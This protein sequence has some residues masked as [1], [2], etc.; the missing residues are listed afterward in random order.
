[1]KLPHRRHFLH[2]AGGA[3]VLP[4]VAR[5]AKAETYPARPVRLIVG[6][7]P[8]GSTDIAARVIAQWL[9]EQSG[10]PFIIENKPGAATNVATE[11][12]VRAPADGYTLLVVNSTNTINA[13][14]YQNLNFNFV[15][16]IQMVAGI[17]RSPLVLE[18]NPALP[19]SSVGDFV[20]YAKADPGRLTFG[21]FGTGTLSHVTAEFFK[22]KAGIN[23]LHVPYRGAAPMLT[24]LIG[25]RVQAAFDAIPSSLP[26]IK[27]GELKALA[28]TTG[29]RFEQLPDLPTVG[30]FLP[31]FE[32]SAFVGIGAP[33]NT[34]PEI[35]EKLNSEI[36]R[37]LA[38][39]D[40]Q[41]RIAELG[42]ATLV[43][44]PTEIT[45]LVAQETEKWGQ[46]IRLANIQPE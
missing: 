43:T 5:I 29:S 20:A 4:A 2:L 28:V 13:T 3:T 9:T 26:H 41:K 7:P 21:S 24:D 39:G 11:A 33:K 42:S 36:N 34:P 19:V 37:G 1:V 18:V 22:T 38:N 17:A 32:A 31:G 14:F 45:Q 8:G 30:E 46:V 35:I 27:A 40:M 6:Y 16:D 12:V 25:G 10:Q 15:K 44:S 23:M